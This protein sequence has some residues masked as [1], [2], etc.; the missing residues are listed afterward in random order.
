MSDL[1]QTLTLKLQDPRK[2]LEEVE[3][4]IECVDL[5]PGSAIE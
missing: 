2:G 4:T 1:R 5:P 3:K